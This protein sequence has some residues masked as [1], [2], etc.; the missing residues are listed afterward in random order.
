VNSS[1]SLLVLAAASSILLLGVLAASIVIG[2]KRR[3]AGHLLSEEIEQAAGMEGRWR[4]ISRDTD[5]ASA[6]AEERPAL[7]KLSKDH[8]AA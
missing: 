6:L 4:Q 3:K 2:S 7:V 5:A 8:A 1:T